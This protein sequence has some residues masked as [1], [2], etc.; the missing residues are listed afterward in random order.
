MIPK[1]FFNQ[2]NTGTL[3]LLSEE[4]WRGIGITQSLGWE[5]YEVHGTCRV[6]SIA[7]GRLIGVAT[8]SSRA[9]RTAVSPA[10]ELRRD[11]GSTGSREA[12]CE[13]EVTLARLV[14]IVWSP[15]FGRWI[16]AG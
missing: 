3:R 4:E 14:R 10:E 2:D 7:S 8:L 5:H 9:S 15:Q 16:I 1:Q 12:A 6:R 13:E 11:A